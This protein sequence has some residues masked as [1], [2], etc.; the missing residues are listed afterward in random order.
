[1]NLRTQEKF[2]NAGKDLGEVC[3][4]TFKCM[5]EA[6]GPE[7]LAGLIGNQV[8]ADLDFYME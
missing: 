2:P 4:D 8:L 3:P 7:L 1:M 5:A 6:V